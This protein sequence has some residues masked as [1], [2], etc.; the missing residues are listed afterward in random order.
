MGKRTQVRKSTRQADQEAASEREERRAAIA[1]VRRER[2]A[3]AHLYALQLDA[4]L[5]YNI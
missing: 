3:Q 1:K 4:A 2:A 5:G